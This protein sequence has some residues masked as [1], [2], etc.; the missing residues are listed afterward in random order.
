MRPV[1]HLSTMR[2]A[3]CE[4]GNGQLRCPVCKKNLGPLQ[5][6][7]REGRDIFKHEGLKTEGMSSKGRQLKRLSLKALQQ[8]RKRRVPPQDVAAA[9]AFGHVAIAHKEL[10]MQ[11][12]PP[13]M[14]VFIEM[15]SATQP[16]L[17]HIETIPQCKRKRTPFLHEE[18]STPTP[19]TKKSK[20]AAVAGLCTKSEVAGNTRFDR[21]AR[22]RPAMVSGTALMPEGAE[23]ASAKRP[24]FEKT[25]VKPA[26][27]PEARKAKDG[28]SSVCRS[29]GVGGAPT[30]QISVGGGLGQLR[31]V[32]GDF[33]KG[34]LSSK[35]PGGAATRRSTM[36]TRIWKGAKALPP[37]IKAEIRRLCRARLTPAMVSGASLMLEGAE[38]VATKRSRLDTKAMV[39]Q[40]LASWESAAG[41]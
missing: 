38:V 11:L 19:K 21:K 34:A 12:S 14:E 26:P 28:S 13:K 36:T 20:D 23:V 6:A 7:L 37:K 24:K 18:K 9:S 10:C 31:E 25:R 1:P 17:P 8:H 35:R 15:Q 29:G 40:H 41:A 3:L 2:Q 39:K 16:I 30:V 5:R 32:C 33:P 27:R 4:K 22:L